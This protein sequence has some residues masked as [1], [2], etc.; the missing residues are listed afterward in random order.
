M[1]LTTACGW[2]YAIVWGFSF[3]P[4]LYLNYTLKTSDSISMDYMCLNIGGYLCYSISLLLQLYNS[5]IITQFM[6]KF[7]GRRPILSNADLFYALHGL[8]IL[9]VLLSQIIF[10]K[11]VWGFH[12]ER[13]NFRIHRLTKMVLL[14][15]ILFLAGNWFF[16]DE[17]FKLLTIAL[18]LAY[19]KILMSLIKYVPQVVH[20]YKRKTMY[21]ISKLQ[22][23]LDA[24]G[25][26]F[27]IL[28][29]W[30]KNDLPILEA[31]DANRGKVG[32][33]LVTLIFAAIFSYQIYLYGSE[34]KYKDKEE[35]LLV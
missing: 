1:L 2:I 11:E 7:D 25:A 24:T 27:C 10:G 13:I 30:L 12:N 5:E 17:K 33:T 28:E 16:G 19:F 35:E 14:S 9:L 15:I 3:Y 20:N 18:N 34:P 32:I 8:F 23:A 29:L 6:V 21:G 22:L 31:I 26:A 4:T